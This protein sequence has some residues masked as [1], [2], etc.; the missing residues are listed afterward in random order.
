[1]KSAKS[2]GRW[3]P[4]SVRRAAEVPSWSE[5]R[6]G[7]AYPTDLQDAEAQCGLI[8]RLMLY[9]TSKASVEALDLS[10]INA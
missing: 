1:M 5:I 7:L 2:D 10:G 4:R 6:S 8:V 3:E 9:G